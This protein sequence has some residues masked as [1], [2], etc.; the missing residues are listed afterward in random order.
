V[1]INGAGGTAKVVTSRSGD[2]SALKKKY[3]YSYI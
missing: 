3:I 1:G 2:F